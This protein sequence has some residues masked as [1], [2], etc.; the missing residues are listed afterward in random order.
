MIQLRNMATTQNKLSTYITAILLSKRYR[1]RK[2]VIF[3]NPLLAS[4]K[5]ERWCIW[6]NIYNAMF[7]KYYSSKQDCW[8]GATNTTLLKT[9]DFKVCRT[10]IIVYYHV[11]KN[12]FERCLLNLVQIF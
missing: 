3:G 1:K 10:S 4:M 5:C 9:N 11:R 8:S 6:M 12:T 2:E 7:G